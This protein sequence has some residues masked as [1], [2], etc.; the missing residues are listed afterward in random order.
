MCNLG[1][2]YYYGRGVEV[3]KQKGFDYFMD[4]ADAGC[5]E[6]N[7]KI[8]DFYRYGD[9]VDKD[10][11]KAFDLYY[12]IYKFLFDK[13]IEDEYPEVFLRLGECFLKG[14]GVDKNIDSAEF[15][16]EDAKEI[17]EDKVN[18]Y[19][20]YQKQLDKVNQLLAEC[21]KV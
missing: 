8:A 21:K 19:F 20:Y 13:N 12:R 9:F 17:Y 16:L 14:I 1:Y 3:D 10:E 11:E 2:C 15:Y 7:M 6:G 5:I 18:V 4:S